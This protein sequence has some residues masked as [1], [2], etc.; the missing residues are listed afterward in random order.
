MGNCCPGS[1]EEKY[2]RE[3]NRE[4]DHD[5][6]GDKEVKKLLLLGA[7]SSGKTTFFKQLKCIHG[8]GFSH[9][10]KQDYQA[11]IENQIIEQ[12]QKLIIRGRELIEDFGDEYGHLELKSSEAR[13]SAAFLEV[14]RRDS[15]INEEVASHIDNLWNEEGIRNTFALRAKLAIPDSCEHFFNNIMRIASVAYVPSEEDILLVRK[16]T[17]GIIEEYFTINQTK[18]HIFDVGGQRNERKKWI[19]CFE[20]VTSVIFVASLSSYDESL[21]EDETVNVMDET[22]HLFGE[23]CNLRWFEKT[24]F[25]LFLNKK[26]LFEKKIT[27]V[28][29]NLCFKEY[30]GDNEYEQGIIMFVCVVYFKTDISKTLFGI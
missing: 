22:L 11:Q 6:R 24:P 16:R 19:H 5:K 28:P 18:F 17:T 12:M 27:Q 26:D 20:N 8:K 2:N 25:I 4:L 9:K 29:L 1:G 3:V 10:D 30:T 15:P 23:V 21:L 7:G 14:L 13:D